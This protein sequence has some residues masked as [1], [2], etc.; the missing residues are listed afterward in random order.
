MIII[1]R[2]EVDDR[3]RRAIRL[4]KDEAGSATRAEI[5]RSII[6]ETQIHFEACMMAM[7]E[8]ENER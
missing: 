4:A 3:T 8:R 5:R 1:V 7:E 2:V 6:E